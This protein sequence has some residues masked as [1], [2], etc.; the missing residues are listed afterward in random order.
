MSPPNDRRVVLGVSGSI[1]AY[2][3]AEIVRL[4]RKVSVDVHVVMT[5]SAKHFITPMT[6]GTLSGNPVT[7]DM[8]AGETGGP[9]MDWG[10]DED[11]VDR[12]QGFH[13]D[14]QPH[15]VRGDPRGL[16]FVQRQVAGGGARRREAA[17]RRERDR[18][19]VRR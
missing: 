7:V 18:R 12:E 2:K 16:A 6:L 14:L 13:R 11:E 3:S 17:R 1:A 15:R 8:F 10:R 4:F 5:P 9:Y 19:G